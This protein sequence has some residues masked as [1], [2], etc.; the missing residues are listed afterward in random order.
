MTPS[1]SPYAIGFDAGI[2]ACRDII[3]R[4]VAALSERPCSSPHHRRLMLAA[5]TAAEIEI[6]GLKINPDDV[7]AA[8]DG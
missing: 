8:A 2:D 1:Q 5:M 3:H 7:K 4:A 6:G